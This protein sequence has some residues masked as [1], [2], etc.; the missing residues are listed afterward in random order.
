MKN[1][2]KNKNDPEFSQ[3]HPFSS[4]IGNELELDEE[5]Y[6]NKDCWQVFPSLLF[7]MQ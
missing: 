6:V 4:L 7:S 2:K 5:I 1:I 3:Q